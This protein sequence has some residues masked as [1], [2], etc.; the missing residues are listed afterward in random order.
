[1]L[2]QDIETLTLYIYS[3]YILTHRKGTKCEVEELRYIYMYVCIS[4]I[5]PLWLI[6]MYI[7]MNIYCTS[8]IVDRDKIC[9]I[10]NICNADR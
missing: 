1:M 6:F 9:A 5:I 3:I 7:H 4:H 8:G 10:F 2:I